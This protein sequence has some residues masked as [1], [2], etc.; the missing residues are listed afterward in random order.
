[1]RL[2]LNNDDAFNITLVVTAPRSP[3][4]VCGGVVGL[5]A[6]KAGDKDTY[7]TLRIVSARSSRVKPASPSTLGSWEK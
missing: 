4:L 5:L 3:L 2:E 6:E 7:L 1:M